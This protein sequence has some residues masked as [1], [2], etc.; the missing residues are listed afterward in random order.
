MLAYSKMVDHLK[1]LIPNQM[2]ISALASAE[3][4]KIPQNTFSVLLKHL[5]NPNQVERMFQ[6]HADLK[7]EQWRKAIKLTTHTIQ[8]N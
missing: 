5:L 1:K 3:K 6:A 2:T 4:T 8:Y 7:L